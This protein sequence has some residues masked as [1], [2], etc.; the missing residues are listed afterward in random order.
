M[1]VSERTEAAKAL[2]G[3]IMTNRWFAWTTPKIFDGP[4]EIRTMPGH[5][6]LRALAAGHT[7][8]ALVHR[9]PRTSLEELIRATH[10]C[11][12]IPTDYVIADALQA[13]RERV[14]EFIGGA[15]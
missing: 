11:A 14:A 7:Y 6:G 8:A 10:Y 5:R 9:S 4:L 13:A 3:L 15:A 12:R 1:T 2:L